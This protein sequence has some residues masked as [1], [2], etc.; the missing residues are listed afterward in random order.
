MIGQFSELVIQVASAALQVGGGGENFALSI[1]S[2]S[3]IQMP[4][5][6]RPFPFQ[7]YSAVHWLAVDRLIGRTKIAR[8]ARRKAGECVVG[9][10]VT[11]EPVSS[12][13]S[14]ITGK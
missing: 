6:R 13:N 8:G 2:A 14:L 5:T 10:A 12:K 9:D 11:V 4:A 3:A 1:F 7:R